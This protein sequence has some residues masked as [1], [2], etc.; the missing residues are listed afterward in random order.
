MRRS[1]LFSALLLCQA[2]FSHLVAGQTPDLGAAST[3]AL[4]AVVGNVS[5]TG[6]LTGIT[7]DVGTNNGAISGF[8]VNGIIGQT[9]S[10]NQATSDASR[11][12]LAAYAYLVGLNGPAAPAIST[13]M[14]GPE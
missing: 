7:G 10:Q 14:G 12:V 11:D 3:F 4:F 1:I 9:H 2:F 6:D 5:N 13:T 8:P